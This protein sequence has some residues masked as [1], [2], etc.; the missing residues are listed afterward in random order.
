MLFQ[1]YKNIPLLLSTIIVITL[2]HSSKTYASISIGLS[3]SS[4]KLELGEGETYQGE[5]TIWHNSEETQNYKIE[6][7]SFQQIENQPGTSIALS[8]E[9]DAENIYSASQWITLNTT[10]ISVVPNKNEKIY[11]T[12]TVPKDIAKGEY[13]AMINFLSNNNNDNTENS[14]TYSVLSSGIPI[15][16]KID[17]EIYEKA[18]IA[19]FTATNKFYDSINI[20]FKT[21]INNIGNTHISPTG[22]IFFSNIFGQ[23]IGSIKFN[24]TG[25]TIL[26]DNTGTYYTN[27]KDAL[28]SIK[29]KTI[30]IGPITATLIITYS[31]N[32]PGFSMLQAETSFWVIPWKYILILIAIITLII[33]VTTKKKKKFKK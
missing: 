6:T 19:S 11:Y 2:L 27:W 25:T 18:E 4:Q 33:I 30:A 32:Q 21:E 3:P 9:E 23:D 24:E 13:Y 10:E 7:T 16:I 20:D 1:K 28:I 14:T 31:S 15:L 12:I 17:G 22:E 26:R 5:I 8:Q 29:N